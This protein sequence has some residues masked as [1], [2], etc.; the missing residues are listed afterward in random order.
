M[1]IE[2]HEIL[3]ML[4]PAAMFGVVALFMKVLFDRAERAASREVR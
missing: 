1:L 3:L 2:T 4:A